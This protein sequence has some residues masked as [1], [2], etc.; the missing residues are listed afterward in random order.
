MKPTGAPVTESGQG[1]VWPSS[2][3]DLGIDEPPIA[4]DEHFTYL[5]DTAFDLAPGDARLRVD[6]RT[7]VDEPTQTTPK[8]GKQKTT[9]EPSFNAIVRVDG[10][11]QHFELHMSGSSLFVQRMTEAFATAFYDEAQESSR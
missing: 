10:D 11:V 8:L 5:P 1:K 6:E 2:P 9:L 4:P 3:A 7:G